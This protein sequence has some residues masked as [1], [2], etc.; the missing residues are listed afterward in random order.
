MVLDDKTIEWLLKPAPSSSAAKQCIERTGW[1][2]EEDFFNFLVHYFQPGKTLIDCI[3]SSSAI[4]T[5]TSWQGGQ[6]TACR[7][8]VAHKST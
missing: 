4:A 5:V 8:Y 7:P 3:S 1:N 6:T 2:D